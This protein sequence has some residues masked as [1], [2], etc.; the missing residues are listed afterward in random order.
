MARKKPQQRKSRK[1]YY[2]IVEGCTEENYIK[3]LK[4][5]YIHQHQ[6]GKLKNCK[7]G[8]AGYVL[9]ETIRMV[10]K[11]KYYY[12]GYISWFDKDTYNQKEDEDLRQ[13][14]QN[15][16]NSQMT[17]DIYISDPCIESWLLAHFIKPK[18]NEKCSF[19]KEQLQ[20]PK[21]I[22]NYQKNN[23]QLL[24][25]HINNENIQI[26]I[27]HYPEIGCLV[28]RYFAIN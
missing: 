7:G 22:P 17:I 6:V 1:T 10:E 2:F 4:D 23:C 5:L 25:K 14:L 15:Q 21:R 19:Y 26:A 16:A 3:C 28:Q 27:A 18:S 9:R 13:N 8:S 12:L 20:Q 24:K 11:Y